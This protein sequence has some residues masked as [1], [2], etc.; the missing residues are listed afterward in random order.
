M[1]IPRRCALCWW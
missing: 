1:K